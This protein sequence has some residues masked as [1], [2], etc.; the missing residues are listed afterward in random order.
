MA[1][2]GYS[3]TG[4]VD[5]INGL[6]AGTESFEELK[7][8]GNADVAGVIN[9]KGRRVYSPNNRP[10]WDDVGGSNV[11]RVGVA[12]NGSTPVIEAQNRW[13]TSVDKLGFL[14][15]KEATG[16]N[17][18]CFL[19][20]STWW[21]GESWV[22][23]YRGGYAQLDG[24]VLAARGRFRSA[25]DTVILDAGN[26]RDVRVVGQNNGTDNWY[27]GASGN[28][29]DSTWFNYHGGSHIRL[30]SNKSIEYNAGSGGGH[31]FNGSVYATHLQTQPGTYSSCRLN[32]N[33]GYFFTME[34]DS[35]NNNMCFIRRT[36][37]AVNVKLWTMSGDGHFK[38]H[39]GAIFDTSGRVY[40]PGNRQRINWGGEATTGWD[41][42]FDGWQD[43]SAPGGCVQTGMV[44]E[45]SNGAEDRRFK[46][47]Y[48][49]IS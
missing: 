47:K 1:R 23:Q 16:G 45:H 30:V 14:P 35:G 32:G 7:V 20:T 28:N 42:N 12:S 26:S 25:G 48:R 38:C 43:W 19:G 33:R 5:F 13:V 36:N 6:V 10:N 40:S 34:F 37:N 15:H 4:L 22:N 18:D 39:N 29:T 41:N 31:Y 3:F 24:D 17:A 8:D 46:F 49:S 21:F 27:I 2:K 44:S 9:E 11:W